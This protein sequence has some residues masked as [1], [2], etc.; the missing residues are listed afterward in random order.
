M[1]NIRNTSTSDRT[2]ASRVPMPDDER[3]TTRDRESYRSASSYW[4]DKKGPGPRV[5]AA[6][7][8]TG[9]DVR[10]DAD[11]KI[12]ELS[13]IMI[14]VPTG[15][16]AYGVLS[17]GGFLG[18]GDKLFAIPWT[19][20]RLDPAE[21][22]FRLNVSKEELENAPGFDKDAWPS[23]ADQQFGDRQWAED[24]HA[25]YHVTPYWE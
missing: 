4:D 19:A 24:I 13:H 10:N 9:D 11:E 20:L 23:T 14:D 25:Y 2:T 16:V 1:A 8:L 22:C 17:I 3:D 12:G 18:I 7:T 6:D 21:H 15:R 5:M